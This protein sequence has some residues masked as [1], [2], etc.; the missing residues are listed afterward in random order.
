M[1]SHRLTARYFSHQTSTIVSPT[2][3]RRVRH[4]SSASLLRRHEA[5]IVTRDTQT[6]ESQ[7][8][9]DLAQQSIFVNK[10]EMSRCQLDSTTQSK[11][12]HVFGVW[13]K[14]ERRTYVY[15]DCRSYLCRPSLRLNRRNKEYT[16]AQFAFDS[17]SIHVTTHLTLLHLMIPNLYAH[18]HRQSH[19][20]DSW[21]MKT[22]RWRR[23]NAKWIDCV[24]ID[25]VIYFI[26]D[27][28]IEGG[29]DERETEIDNS[30]NAR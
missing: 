30:A 9:C 14:R 23:K 25:F 17:L 29:K 19:W 13:L 21:V 24:C 7:F 4:R 12:E 11:T 16:W 22:F 27:D 3:W 20:P 8:S 26:G 10:Y 2:H 28:A 18:E 15:N 1:T 5:K 6:H